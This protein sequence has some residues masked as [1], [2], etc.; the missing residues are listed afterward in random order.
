MEIFLAVVEEGSF[1]AAARRARISAPSVTR[2]IALLE[3]RVGQVLFLRNTRSVS[4]SD[5]GKS[6][7]VDCRHIIAE[8]REAEATAVGHHIEPCGLLTVA[9]PVQF[10]Q[11]F[12][13]PLVSDYLNQFPEVRLTCLFVDQK[14]DMVNENV[15]LSIRVGELES[16]SIHAIKIGEVRQIVCASPSF[17]QRYGRPEEPEQL[18]HKV[19]VDST[20]IGP[21][22]VWHFQSQDR[23]LEIILDSRVNVTTHAAAINIARGGWGI[24]RALLFQVANDVQEGR[25]ELLL[26]DY[27]PAPLPVHIVFRDQIKTASKTYSFADFLIGHI[28][29][30]GQVTGM[31]PVLCPSFRK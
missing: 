11:S 17:L 16:E 27:E 12:I 7:L 25:L 5:A 29:S 14:I 18:L 30:V 8:T 24:T 26:E 22:Q 21:T 20:T 10:G 15:D 19:I 31:E 23:E 3:Q 2:S 6:F 4:L 13:A 9:A 1:A 28:A